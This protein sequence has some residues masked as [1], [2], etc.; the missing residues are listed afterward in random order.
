MS[1]NF[2][3]L[4]REK[5]KLEKERDKALLKTLQS[6]LDW[7]MF[8]GSE[9]KKLLEEYKKI[10]EDLKVIQQHLE[11]ELASEVSDKAE[12]WNRKK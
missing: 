9:R 6:I 7:E 2:Y 11:L 12:F 4:L 5:N 1:K 10:M 3:N 8:G